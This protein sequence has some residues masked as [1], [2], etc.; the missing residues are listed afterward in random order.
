MVFHEFRNFPAGDGTHAQSLRLVVLDVLPEPERQA[1]VAVYPPNPDMSVEDGQRS[2]FQS[3]WA[4]G[5]V[6]CLYSTGVPRSG[7]RLSLLARR[8]ASVMITSTDSPG[9]KG[10]SASTSWPSSAIVASTRCVI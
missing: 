7:Y 6:G 1:R 8:G 4:T 10:K 3:P 5:R 2:T 9:L